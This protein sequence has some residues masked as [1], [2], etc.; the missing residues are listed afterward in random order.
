M[1]CAE[2]GDLKM[3]KFLLHKKI[4]MNMQDINGNTEFF[5]SLKSKNFKKAKYLIRHGTNIDHKN[6]QNVF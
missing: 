1:L 3:L 2:N 5:Y 4:Y 6:L